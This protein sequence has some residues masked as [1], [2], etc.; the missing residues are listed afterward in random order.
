MDVHGVEPA[1]LE[2]TG[3]GRRTE[4]VAQLGRVEPDPGEA[5]RALA[6]RGVGTASGHDDEPCARRG[7]EGAG[8]VVDPSGDD[9][10]VVPAPDLCSGECEA[11]LFGA[12]QR[13]EQG[14]G[15]MCDPHAAPPART[16]RVTAS[17]RSVALRSH[18]NRSRIV[19]ARRVRSSA[20]VGAVSAAASPSRIASVEVGST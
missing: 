5:A 2:E 1:V 11:V 20:A 7:H 15:H 17:W 12:A 13:T 19:A 18:E 10:D 6:V 4:G 16:R 3:D 9:G 14:A 8:A